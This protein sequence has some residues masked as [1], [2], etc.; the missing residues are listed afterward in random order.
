V[1][2]ARFTGAHAQIGLERDHARRQARE[3][4]REVRALGLGILLGAP[5]RLACAAQTL[6]HVVERVH[7]KAHLVV[8]RQWQPRVEIALGDGPGALDEVLDRLH[9]ALRREDGAVPRGEQ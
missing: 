5:L 4:H 9:E 8:R 6:G 3:D 1:L 7:E 2:A